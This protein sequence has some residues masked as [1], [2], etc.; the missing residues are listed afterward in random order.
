MTPLPRQTRGWSK[1]TE[2]WKEPRWFSV[3]LPQ[4]SNKVLMNLVSNCESNILA[5]SLTL[6]IKQATCSHST[7][8]LKR[9]AHRGVSSN[10]ITVVLWAFCFKRCRA[11]GVSVKY[12]K[13]SSFG[14]F[15]LTEVLKLNANYLVQWCMSA[16]VITIDW[17]H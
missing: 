8:A 3:S 17:M 13:H 7:N 15:L 4:T 9:P 2:T 1:M 5:D 14:A 16:L 6:T 11:E 12:V 10:Q